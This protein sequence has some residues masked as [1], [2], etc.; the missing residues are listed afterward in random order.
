MPVGLCRLILSE[1][2]SPAA[3]VVSAAERQQRGADV[4]KIL[5]FIRTMKRLREVW[6]EAEFTVK[7]RLLPSFEIMEAPEWV[8]VQNLLARFR[9]IYLDGED[10][11]FRNMVKILARHIG[12]TPPG[13]PL[14]ELERRWD[15][16]LN[17]RTAVLPPGTEVIGPNVV[18]VASGET[19]F[20]I[21][22]DG[23]ALSGR[24]AIDL[25]VYGELVHVDA[26]KERKRLRIQASHVE[27]AYRVAVMQVMTSLVYLADTLRAYSEVFAGRFDK[28]QLE[29]IENDVGT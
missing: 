12:V 15:T 1:T 28:A 10:I 26:A 14:E 3:E 9:P 20:E 19:R 29:R 23:T 25:S 5:R 6:P 16:A 17:G 24:E 4:R 21:G 7:A 13:V 11:S 27:P 18:A 22:F 8:D 2:D